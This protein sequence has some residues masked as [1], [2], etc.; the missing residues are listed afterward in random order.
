MPEIA[1]VNMN[2]L[3]YTSKGQYVSK[4]VDG[5]QVFIAPLVL[6]KRLQI[7]HRDGIWRS[8]EGDEPAEI[9]LLHMGDMKFRAT[10][11]GTYNFL[12]IFLFLK[13]YPEFHLQWICLRE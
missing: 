11:V 6:R 2:F 8:Y 3:Q 4:P 1:L 5:I 12:Q 7:I 10:E 13:F 9:C